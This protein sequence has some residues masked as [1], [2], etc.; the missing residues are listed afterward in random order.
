VLSPRGRASRWTFYIGADGKIL[1]IDKQV[2][3]ATAGE[4]LVRK[5]EELGVPKK[6]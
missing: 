2:R 4:D 5:L 6:K 3:P 1:A